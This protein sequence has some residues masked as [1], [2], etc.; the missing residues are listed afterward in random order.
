VELVVAAMVD[1]KVHPLQ[2]QSPQPQELQ[3]QAVVA[4]VLEDTL[5]EMALLVG[6]ALSFSNTQS[7]LQLQILLCLMLLDHGL[8]Q[9]VLLLLIILL[10]VEAVAAV[11]PLEDMLV[12]EAVLADLELEQE[13]L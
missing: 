11:V 7:L 3:I 6:L 4:V 8:H 12:V 5:E 9:L 2:Q 1:K 13:C 10:S